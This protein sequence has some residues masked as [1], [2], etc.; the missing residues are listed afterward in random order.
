M[1]NDQLPPLLDDCRKAAATS[2]AAGFCSKGIVCLKAVEIARSALCV[3]QTI[4]AKNHDL[5]IARMRRAGSVGR[6][7]KPRQWTSAKP[8]LA[9]SG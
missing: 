8:Q 1:P 2:P 4:K 9:G 5:G 6:R 3:V 7:W